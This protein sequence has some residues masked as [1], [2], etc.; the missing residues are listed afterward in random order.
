MLPETS[1]NNCTNLCIST[2][3]LHQFNERASCELVV[4]CGVVVSVALEKEPELYLIG[5]APLISTFWTLQQKKTKVRMMNL[6]KGE[7]LRVDTHLDNYTS[8]HDTL[9]VIAAHYAGL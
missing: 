9:R 7:Q 8:L 3:L 4:D 5:S 1:N 2:S 6:H